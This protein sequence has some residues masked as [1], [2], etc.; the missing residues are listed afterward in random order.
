M[1]PRES[2]PVA[3]QIE[4]CPRNLGSD[5]RVTLGPTGSTVGLGRGGAGV[6]DWRPDTS[7][8]AASST[9]TISNTRRRII[10]L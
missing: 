2:W 6:A 5:I 7:A 9:G 1:C 8:E 3:P 10:H 4:N